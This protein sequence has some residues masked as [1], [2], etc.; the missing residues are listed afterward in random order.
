MQTT[1]TTNTWEAKHKLYN[2]HTSPW[3]IHTAIQVSWVARNSSK[4]TDTVYKLQTSRRHAGELLPHSQ[5]RGEPG[6]EARWTYKL[7]LAIIP[8]QYCKLVLVLMQTKSV[9]SSL[10]HPWTALTKN[11]DL[12]YDQTIKLREKLVTYMSQI[13][14]EIK[15]CMLYCIRSTLEW[16]YNGYRSTTLSWYKVLMCLT[17]QHERVDNVMIQQLKV[18]MADP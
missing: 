2:V 7:Q 12:T 17:F 6:N 4:Y 15:W 10:C 9:C 13:C 11:T 5:A 1:C 3:N 16:W 14:L 18:F 8:M